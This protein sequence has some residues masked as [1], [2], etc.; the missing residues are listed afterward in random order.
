MGSLK[1]AQVLNHPEEEDQVHWQIHDPIDQWSAGLGQERER[2]KA[3][4]LLCFEPSE[5]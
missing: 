5:D 3:C 1:S 2:G 4:C